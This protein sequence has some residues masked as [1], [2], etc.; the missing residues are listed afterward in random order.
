MFRPSLRRVRVPALLAALL[1]LALTVSPAAKAQ[2]F[3]GSVNADTNSISASPA[4]PGL[5]FTPTLVDTGLD[6]VAG[7]RITGTAT[8]TWVISGND[9]ITDANGQIGRTAGPW[10]VSSLLGQ[11]SDSG[12]YQYHAGGATPE[13]VEARTFFLGSSFD[14]IAGSTGR[15]YL[16]FNDTDYGNNEGSVNVSLAVTS[17]TVPEP[18]AGALALLCL[19]PLLLCRAA[20]RSRA[21]SR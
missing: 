21:S 2:T 10:W 15:L 4:G 18:S 19:L 17:A 8:G 13:D 11:I 1:A 14:L 6:V 20:V 16:A 5:T 3:T 7:D 12:P 9:P